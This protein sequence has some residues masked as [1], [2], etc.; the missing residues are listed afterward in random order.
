MIVRVKGV[1][2]SD[3]IIRVSCG[4]DTIEIELPTP[5][6]AN[7]ADPI[8]MNPNNIPVTWLVAPLSRDGKLDV[9]AAIKTIQARRADPHELD[10]K[11]VVVDIPD[12]NLH[13]LADF[14]KRASQIMPDLP[15]VL[16]SK[17]RLP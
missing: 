5:A 1:P 13:D 6:A 10:Y 9:D 14:G 7:P 12:A 2:D 16:K 15:I 3:G 4:A 11:G 8:P 17:G